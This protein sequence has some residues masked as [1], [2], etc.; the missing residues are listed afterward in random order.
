MLVVM[1][2]FHFQ[3]TV[4]DIVKDGKGNSLIP[5]DRNVSAEAFRIVFDHLIQ[6]AGRNHAQELKIVLAGDVFDLHRSQQ[7][8]KNNNPV[9]PYGRYG[10]ADWGPIA[11]GILNDIIRSN[12]ET[13]TIFQTFG[14][15]QTVKLPGHD[16][17]IPF[18]FEYIP[19]NHDRIINLYPPLLDAVCNLL[20]MQFQNN[21]PFQNVGLFEKYGAFVCHGHEYDRYNFAGASPG[22]QAS[23]TP[24][25]VYND[26]P[27]G[28]YMTIDIAT[29]MAYEYREQNESKMIDGPDAGMHRAA[30]QKLLEFDDVRPQS[31]LI[32]FMEAEIGWQAENKLWESIRPVL[33]KVIQQA[34]ES[35]FMADWLNRLNKPGLD[36]QDLIRFSLERKLWSSMTAISSEE[37]IRFLI[38]LFSGMKWDE[39]KL[40]ERVSHEPILKN[41]AYRYVVAGHTHNPA[42]EFLCHRQSDRRDIFFFDTGTWR[43]QIRKCRDNRT[44]ARAK[45][46]TYVIFYGP[47]EDP[48]RTSKTKGYSFDYWS[49]FTKKEV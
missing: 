13:F 19:G 7:W 22:N 30:Y 45:A 26:A 16:K 23:P 4:S 32:A 12:I 8:F 28:D 31:E 24:S 48:S 41:K 27:I 49:G 44:F 35:E 42:V 2:D 1:S 18:Q 33:V 15:Q 34:L 47:N 40:W 46:L 20:G 36:W 29:R 38:K 21:M 37:L 39:A 14:S 11:Q 17:E 3:D 5:V 9:R 43:Q 25:S 10:P 6:I